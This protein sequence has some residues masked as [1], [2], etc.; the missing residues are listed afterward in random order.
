VISKRTIDN[1]KRGSILKGVPDYFSPCGAKDIGTVLEV[2]KEGLRVLM[3]WSSMSDVQW[4][5]A[6]WLAYWDIISC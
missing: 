4:Y 3:L 6:V 2:D 1:L 5:S